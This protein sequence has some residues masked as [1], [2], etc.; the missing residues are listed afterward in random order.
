[1]ATYPAIVQGSCPVVASFGARDV[2]NPGRGPR[3]KKA[4]DAQGIANDVKVYS[5]VGHS[6][7]N[8]MPGQPFLRIVGFGHDAPTTDDAYRRVF[9]FFGTH[10]GTASAE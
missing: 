6:F 8:E 2:V 10:L 1:M 3:L 7:A 4:L 5:G 9:D